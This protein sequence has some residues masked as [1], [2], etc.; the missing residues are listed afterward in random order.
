[1]SFSF[2]SLLLLLAALF[3]LLYHLNS[4]RHKW[5]FLAHHFDYYWPQTVFV[6]PTAFTR[7]IVAVGDLHGDYLNAF[8]V[9]KFSGVVDDDG[10][11]T[12]NAD[13]FVQTGD[14]I[15]RGDDTIKL[16]TWM[17][18]LREQASST[19]GVVLSHLGNHEW[20]NALGK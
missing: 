1:M 7:H 13:F 17:D 15:D 19:G 8:K 5:L 20:M 9:L 3:Y 11:W 16:F 18:K 6:Q 2:T 12:G 10:N 14:I 4:G